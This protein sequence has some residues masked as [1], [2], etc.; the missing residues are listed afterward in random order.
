M[1]TAAIIEHE[2]DLGHRFSLKRSIR[3]PLRKFPC[4]G[5]ESCPGG[6]RQ[7]FVIRYSTSVSTDRFNENRASRFCWGDK[8]LKALRSKLTDCSV[9]FLTLVVVAGAPILVSIGVF[10]LF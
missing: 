4:A 10:F 2:V 8:K 3:I 6:I 9:C 1:R 5:Q 7:A